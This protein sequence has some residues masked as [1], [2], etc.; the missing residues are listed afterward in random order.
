MWMN[1]FRVG[2]VIRILGHLHDLAKDRFLIFG[3]RD[4]GKQDQSEWAFGRETPLRKKA[5]TERSDIIP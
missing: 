2:K 1:E 5:K 3:L 4:G